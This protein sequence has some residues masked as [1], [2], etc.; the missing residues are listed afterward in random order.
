MYTITEIRQLD[1]PPKAA[2]M[3]SKDVNSYEI[4]PPNQRGVVTVVKDTTHVPGLLGNS[5]LTLI[6]DI[7]SEEDCNKLASEIEGSDKLRQYSRRKG[8]VDEPRL[9]ALAHHEANSSDMSKPGV[10]YSYK[11]V[12]MKG[13]PIDSFPTL[14]KIANYLSTLLDVPEW[15]LGCDCIAY[16]SASDGIGWHADKSQG[17]TVIAC[18][19]IA[20]G[21]KQRRVDIK[22]ASKKE[23]QTKYRLKLC[24]GSMYVMNGEMQQHYLH[25]LL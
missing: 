20:T 19:I 25:S 6:P 9:H 17:E 23:T 8:V 2:P 18:L 4:I 11:D 3:N 10:G 12:N 5:R 16:A 14:G 24:Q 21:P 13:I 1:A 22:P 7:I 15:S